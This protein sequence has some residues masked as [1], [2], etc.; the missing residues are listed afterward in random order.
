MNRSSYFDY[1]ATTPVDPHVLETMLPFFV[2]EFGN[3]SSIHEWGQK[4]DAALERSREICSKL[5]RIS[6][7][8][9]IFT[10]GGTES[11]NLALRGC[12]LYQR[13][14]N[15][16]DEMVTTPVEHHAVANTAS[17]LQEEFG[18]KLITVPVDQYGMVD[19]IEVKKK[20]SRKTAIVSIIYGNNEIGTVNPISEIGLLCEEMKIPFHSDAVQAAAHLPMNLEKDHLNMISLGAH[21]MYGPKGIGLLGLKSM[22]GLVPSQTGGGQ[23]FNLRAGTQ[24][25]PLIVGLAEAFQIAQ[26]EIELRNIRISSLRDQLIH[27]ILDSIPGA[28]LTGHPIK[29]LPN[30]ASFVF[31]GVD[32]NRLIMILDSKGFACSSGSAC[33]VGSPT[34]SDV[35]LAIGLKPDLAMGSLRITLGRESTVEQ[36]DALVLAIFDAVK[37]I[38]K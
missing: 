26:R 22:A 34:P 8:E 37:R 15:G 29:R 7:D 31:K 6:P 35:L 21:K 5:L 30:H 13:K 19:P 25:I 3:P 16:A 14:I 38:R 24:N 32:G 2:E 33:K 27:K 10:S 28:Q 1:A 12:A 36:V 4:A 17:Q 18:F 11:D 23:E 9:V 20:L